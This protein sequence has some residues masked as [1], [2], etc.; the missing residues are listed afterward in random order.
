MGLRDG[1]P[2]FILVYSFSFSWVNLQAKASLSQ[3]I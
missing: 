1:L 2:Y 3:G